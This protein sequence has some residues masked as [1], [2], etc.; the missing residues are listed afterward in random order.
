M[1]SHAV[2]R[3]SHRP[4]ALL[5]RDQLW[6]R[7]LRSV[8]VRPDDRRR[9]LCL[10][11]AAGQNRGVNQAQADQQRSA[12]KCQADH[13]TPYGRRQ[14]TAC[15]NIV[16]L[17]SCGYERTALGL[18]V[19]LPSSPGVAVRLRPIDSTAGDEVPA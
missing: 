11:K 2:D 10:R 7:R 18:S 16:D 14:A 6:Y 5:S 12:G 15:S 4:G 19:K 3:A 17:Q 8:R 1:E 13:P 9:R